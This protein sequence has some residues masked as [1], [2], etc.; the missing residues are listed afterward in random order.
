MRRGGPSVGTSV[1]PS[2]LGAGGQAVMKLASLLA[3]FEFA[4]RVCAICGRSIPLVG[5]RY[6]TTCYDEAG[7]P[8]GI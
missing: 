8:H 6:C 5:H 3:S 7:L 2:V 1:L 4:A